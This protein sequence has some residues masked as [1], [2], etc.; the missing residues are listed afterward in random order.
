MI[1]NEI[2]ENKILKNK[3][4]ELVDIDPRIL[5]KSS[6]NLREEKTDIEGL[7]KSIKTLGGVLSPVLI[8]E[9][10]EVFAGW[11]RVEASRIANMKTI[12]C[13]RIYGLTPHEEEVLSLTENVTQEE[14]R[15]D[16]LIKGLKK[17]LEDEDDVDKLASELGHS[18][19]WIDILVRFETRKD[20]VNKYPEES[21]EKISSGLNKSR[22]HKKKNTAMSLLNTPVMV[23]NPVNAE[24][25]VNNLDDIPIRSLE[26]MGEEARHDVPIDV[27]YRI[28]AKE[29]E[30]RQ[31]Y[32]DKAYLA[33][34]FDRCKKQ[35]VD[36]EK[37]V[38]ELIRDFG[39][40][41]IN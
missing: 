31:F 37:K 17:L 39:N 21:K 14:L 30:L 29:R 34:F 18:P 7:A 28:T 22:E 24:K 9:R 15:T 8:N 10:N 16:D 32:F 5:V 1:E 13:L 19:S 4:I 27:D 35:N 6:T 25:I 2:L 33:S 41:K 3:K 11:R 26:E 36:P 20:V 40:Y 23:K 38:N 12:K